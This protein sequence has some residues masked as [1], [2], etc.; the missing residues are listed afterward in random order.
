MLQILSWHEEVDRRWLLAG[1][2][3]TLSVVTCAAAVHEVS[4]EQVVELSHALSRVNGLV[5]LPI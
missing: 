3:V 1:R 5:L 4:H 2:R